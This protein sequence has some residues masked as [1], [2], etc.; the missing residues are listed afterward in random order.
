MPLARLPSDAPHRSERLQLAPLQ[1]RKYPP[2]EQS[3]RMIGAMRMLEAKEVVKR[4]N[5]NL[6]PRAASEEEPARLKSERDGRNEQK[7]MFTS[8]LNLFWMTC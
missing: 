6:R 7:L 3:D 1:K 8:A 5:P 2:R 4:S